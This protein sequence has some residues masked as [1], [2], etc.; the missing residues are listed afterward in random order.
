MKFDLMREFRE[1]LRSEYGKNTAD[2]YYFAVKSLFDGL[3]FDSAQEICGEEVQRRMAKVKTKNDYSAAKC[4]LKQFSA[5]FPAFDLPGES[6]FSEGSK[7]KRN[8]KKRIFEP[9][10]LDTIKRKINGMQNNR[11]KIAYRLML[12]SGA[13]VSEVAALKS[14]DIEIDGYNV[15]IRIENGKGGKSRVI[16][17]IEDEYL[18]REL[19][20]LMEASAAGENIF[21]S[22]GHMKNEAGELGLECHDLRRA[23]SKV[24]LRRQKE[25]APDYETAKQ[26]VMDAMGHESYRTTKRYIKRKIEI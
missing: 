6:F 22:A 12:A 21:D 10:K 13:R 19:P 17:N 24:Y 23:F 25:A 20:R 1:H 7:H 16:S 2:K 4:G 8:F 15:S 11:L 26:N 14:E 9:V 18:S 5:C 3:N